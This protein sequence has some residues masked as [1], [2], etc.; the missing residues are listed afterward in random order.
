MAQNI[1]TPD[2]PKETE[3]QIALKVLPWVPTLEYRGMDSLDFHDISVGTIKS[4][5]AEA[6]KA[7]YRHGRAD[8][9]IESET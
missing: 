4:L 2:I 7:G 5:I 9:T 3:S 1:E 6:Y 8:H